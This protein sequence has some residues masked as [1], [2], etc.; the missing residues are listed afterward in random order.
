MQLV[1]HGE[2]A[3]LCVLRRHDLVLTEELS[4]SFNQLGRGRAEVECPR[5]LAE[6]SRKRLHL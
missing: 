3:V 4:A 1:K 6:P 2:D 5:F